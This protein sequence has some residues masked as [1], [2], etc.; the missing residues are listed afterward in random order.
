MLYAVLKPEVPKKRKSNV[1]LQVEGGRDE[2]VDTPVK[3]RLKAAG[4]AEP[5]ARECEIFIFGAQGC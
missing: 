2:S 5:R 1:N 3:K 4:S